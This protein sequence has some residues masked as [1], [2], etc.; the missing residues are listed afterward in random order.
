MLW[1]AE[2][3]SIELPRRIERLVE[4][5]YNLWWSCTLRDE[6]SFESSTTVFERP[7]GTTRQ[8]TAR[9]RS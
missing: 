6:D 9:D 2:G 4:L 8:D 5:T 3:S 7:A 1:A